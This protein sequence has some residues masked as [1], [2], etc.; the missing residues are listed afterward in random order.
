MAR[1][2]D[3]MIRIAAEGTAVHGR[4]GAGVARSNIPNPAA[5]TAC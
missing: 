1:F 5:R 3:M 4:D 2:A